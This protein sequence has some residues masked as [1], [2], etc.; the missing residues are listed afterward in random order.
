M[1]EYSIIFNEKIGD[2]N[3]LVTSGDGS[4]DDNIF[5]KAHFWVNDNKIMK[6][7]VPH[8][9]EK[10]SHGDSCGNVELFNITGNEI[11][12][13]NIADYNAFNFAMHLVELNTIGSLRDIHDLRNV[14]YHSL[15]QMGVFIDFIENIY[16]TDEE[17]IDFL[18]KT[19]DELKL[20]L[21]TN[22]EKD[23]NK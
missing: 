8:F 21:K 20:I 22:E 12:K 14:I 19:K 15:T 9:N 1:S 10:Y 6:N 16:G 5:F 18:S 2:Y 23:D 7:H 13:S 3:F 4:R 17:K 11:F